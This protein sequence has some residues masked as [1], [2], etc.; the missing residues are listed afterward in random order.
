MYKLRQAVRADSGAI[1][2]LVYQAWLNPFGLNWR[3]FVI[4]ES[5]QGQ[6]IGCGQVKVHGDGSRELAS[7]VVS[8]DWRLRGVAKAL[9]EHLVGTHPKPIYLTCRS[10]LG[11]FYLRFGFRVIEEAKMPPYFQRISRLY[12]LFRRFF[13]TGEGLLVMKHPG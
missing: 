7:I 2:A 13:P 4:A 11:K 1:R 10:S 8:P 12:R 6:V 5:A 9:I 3:R